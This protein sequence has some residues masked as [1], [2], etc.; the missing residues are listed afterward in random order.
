MPR[1]EGIE[2]P[3][4]N[5]LHTEIEALPP[6]LRTEVLDFVRFVKQQHGLPTAP[7]A[8]ADDQDEGDSPFFQAL[9]AAGFIGCIET[10]EQLSTTYKNRLDFSVK[11]G[12]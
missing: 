9:S 10:A 2:M 3:T 11:A 1:L 7:A 4:L 6:N 8:L 5:D 12:T